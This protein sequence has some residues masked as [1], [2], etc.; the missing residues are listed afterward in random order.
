MWRRLKYEICDGNKKKFIYLI[1]NRHQQH[2]MNLIII[3]GK[4]K[5]LSNK[6]NHH[7]WIP[8]NLRILFCWFVNFMFRHIFMNFYTW[9]VWLW[10]RISVRL[11]VWSIKY[12]SSIM[13][14]SQIVGMSSA[15]RKRVL[16]RQI[17]LVLW[18]IILYNLKEAKD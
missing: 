15:C 6:G 7:L 16:E 11:A 4:D 17:L 13:R 14:S 2:Q 12:A 10:Y 9:I 8:F 3:W 18:K 1:V 5:M